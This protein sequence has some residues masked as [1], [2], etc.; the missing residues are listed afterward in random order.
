VLFATMAGRWGCRSRMLYGEGRA[1]VIRDNSAWP[2]ACVMREW[3]LYQGFVW[4][5]L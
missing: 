4:W 2:I 1:L 3:E 5:W